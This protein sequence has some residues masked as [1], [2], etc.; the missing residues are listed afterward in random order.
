MVLYFAESAVHD[1]LKVNRFEFGLVSCSEL[2]E[3]KKYNERLTKF[4]FSRRAPMFAVLSLN[5]LVE[6]PCAGDTKGLVI[7][8]CDVVCGLATAKGFVAGV[9]GS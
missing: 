9:L 6:A 7:G 4:K 8:A 5:S 2:I 3:S 1:F